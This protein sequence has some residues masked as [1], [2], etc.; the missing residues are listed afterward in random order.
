MT[1]TIS[2]IPE[3]VVGLSKT[4]LPDWVQRCSPGGFRRGVSSAVAY[5]APVI[6]N[7]AWMTHVRATLSFAAWLLFEWDEP[8]EWQG[9]CEKAPQEAKQRSSLRLAA[10]FQW[11][12]GFPCERP[13]APHR[14]NGNQQLDEG[15]PVEDS[16][17][18]YRELKSVGANVRLTVYP[19]S[20]TM[21]GTGPMAR[22]SCRNGF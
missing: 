6:F 17:G 19:E 22:K 8:L 20:G 21:P 14:R 3:R 11:P 9:T 4:E 1:P 10:L 2:S 7:F 15:V 13:K 16:K 5:P 12:G 18:L